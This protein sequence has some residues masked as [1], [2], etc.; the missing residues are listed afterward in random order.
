MSSTGINNHPFALPI[1]RGVFGGASEAT[2]GQR[3]GISWQDQERRCDPSA[4]LWCQFFKNPR[5]WIMENVEYRSLNKW[6]SNSM[7]NR[8]SST[9]SGPLSHLVF[10]QIICLHLFLFHLLVKTNNHHVCA[11]VLFFI[12][13]IIWQ[14]ATLLSGH[15]FLNGVCVQWSVFSGGNMSN[16]I[17]CHESSGFLPKWLIT[18]EQ[19]AIIFLSNSVRWGTSAFFGLN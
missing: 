10:S 8:P 1:S 14:P 16:S 9:W 13:C 4:S 5:D 3:S 11:Q 15:S 2:R 6:H 19:N 18:S 7:I 12:R 17:S